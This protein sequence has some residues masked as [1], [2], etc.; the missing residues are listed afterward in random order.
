M[1]QK[2]HCTEERHL[3]ITE[4]VGTFSSIS[5]MSGINFYWD[6]GYIKL[7]I[8]I[9]NTRINLVGSVKTSDSCS[10]ETW[11]LIPKYLL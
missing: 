7:D 4:E 2:Q 1:N 6:A 3:S 8:S 9:K 11:C 10:R 5:K